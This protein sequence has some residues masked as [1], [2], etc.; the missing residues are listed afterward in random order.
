MKPI[1]KGYQLISLCGAGGYTF[2]AYP[3]S[4]AMKNPSVFEGSQSLP[5]TESIVVLL[6]KSSLELPPMRDDFVIFMDNYYSSVKLF[7]YLRTNKIGAVGTCKKSKM[8]KDHKASC[9]A[10]ESPPWGAFL[11]EVV[12]DD[13]LA[14]MWLINN[15]WVNLLTTYHTGLE[16]IRRNRR[17][18]RST[19]AN[20]RTVR[21]AFGND[22]RKIL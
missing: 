15:A 6:I 13:D 2:A 14:L 18:P 10:L 11:G 3:T 19:S 16:V 9:E 21:R 22:P 17:R 12:D 1:P 7:H 8:P 20:A 5:L 4:G